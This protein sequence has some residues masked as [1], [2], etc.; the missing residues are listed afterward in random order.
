MD[1][2]LKLTV[3]ASTAA[4]SRAQILCFHLTISTH[5]PC[6]L[7]YFYQQIQLRESAVFNFLVSTSFP[8]Y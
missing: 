7:S 6:C 2:Q 1:C 3:C 5:D 4:E 8:A